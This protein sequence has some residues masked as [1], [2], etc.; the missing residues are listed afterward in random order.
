MS[1]TS[2]LIPEDTTI[3]EVI[4]EKSLVV[5]VPLLVHFLLLSLTCKNS[6]SVRKEVQ[7]KGRFFRDY[8]KGFSQ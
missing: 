4:D 8:R 2:Y 3:F 7:M 6:S 5:V 1:S